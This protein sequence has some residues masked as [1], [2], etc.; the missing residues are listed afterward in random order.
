MRIL[1]RGFLI[2]AA[3]SSPL[4][5]NLE[6]VENLQAVLEM[7]SVIPEPQPVPD[8]PPTAHSISGKTYVMDEVSDA[9]WE[10][11]RLTFPGGA[12]AVAYILA[13]EIGSEFTLG[14]D[15]L[16]RIPPEELGVPDDAIAAVRG[17][18]EGENIFMLEYDFIFGADRNVLKFYFE[19]NSVEVTIATPE[20]DF[21]IASGQFN[22]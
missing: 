1:T 12:E 4:L 11:I 3:S 9:G 13:G 19:G 18:W 14:L 21:T 15:G 8:L 6:G 20:G 2:E 17:W 16:Y 5:Q 10:E 7:V 22:P